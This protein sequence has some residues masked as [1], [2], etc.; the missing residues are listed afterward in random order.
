MEHLLTV[1][2]LAERLQVKPRTVYQWVQE[3]YVPVIKLGSLVRFSPSNVSKWLKTRE[4]PGRTGRR[5]KL[6]LS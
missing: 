3:R 4:V 2:E 1:E 5:F 6:D